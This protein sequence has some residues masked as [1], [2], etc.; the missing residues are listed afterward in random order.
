M[1]QQG[2]AALFAMQDGRL[3][4]GVQPASRIQGGEVDAS[5]RV[6]TREDGGRATDAPNAGALGSTRRQLSR[7]VLLPDAPSEIL[8]SKRV[9]A[10]HSNRTIQSLPAREK[11]R[12]K[13]RYFTR[14]R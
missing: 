1:R 8:I 6:A 2:S 9:L 14:D 4:D 12:A 7:P 13:Q 11:R 10:T 5:G 3:G